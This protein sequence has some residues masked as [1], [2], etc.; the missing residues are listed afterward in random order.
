[1]PAH[2]FA[3]SFDEEL[4]KNVARAAEEDTGGNVS[5]WLA[6]AARERLRKVEAWKLLK[7]LEAEHGPISEEELAEVRRQWPE[8]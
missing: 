7:E 1:M 2:K 6:E 5:A 8:A 4:A 3:I